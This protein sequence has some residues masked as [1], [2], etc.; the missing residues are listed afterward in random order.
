M[1][2]KNWKMWYSVEDGKRCGECEEN[3]GKIYAMKELPDPKPKLHPWCRCWIAAMRA[4]Y[5]GSVS[6]AGFNGADWW[7]RKHGQLPGNYITQ[8]GARGLGW[9][10]EKGNLSDMLP[11]KTIGGDIYWNRNGHLPSTPG[12]V[13]HEADINYT[14]GYR[15]TERI[16]YS[17]DGLIFVTYDHYHT[18]IEII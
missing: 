14:G 13:W 17:N 4:V 1:Q 12:R 2:S 8:R 11:G 7:V 10:S 15:G 9:R 16:V 3:T 6:R 18:F 5:A